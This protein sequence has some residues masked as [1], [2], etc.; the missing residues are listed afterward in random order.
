M[1]ERS[2]P[3]RYQGSRKEAD[4]A[5][6]ALAAGEEIKGWH[7]EPAFM[8]GM[9]KEPPKLHLDGA[10]WVAWL[11]EIAAENAEVCVQ[12]HGKQWQYAVDDCKCLAEKYRAGEGR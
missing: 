1:G 12:V 4:N 3:S 7:Y 11:Y 9:D 8:P 2:F 6:R 10:A 5:A